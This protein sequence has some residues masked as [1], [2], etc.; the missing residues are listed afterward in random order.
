MNR[1]VD[2]TEEDIKQWE[3]ERQAFIRNEANESILREPP[4]EIWYAGNWLLRQLEALNCTK[5]LADEIA[6]A[7]GQRQAYAKDYWQ[8]VIE[9]VENYKKGQWES[10]G[11]GLAEKLIKE[12]F[13][14]NPDPME[15][16]EQLVRDGANREEL[17][18]LMMK[19][20]LKTKIC[21]KKPE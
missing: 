5:E 14:D 2:V 12:R 8:T 15:I 4:A 10:P 11:A 6:F 16:L 17:L 20:R 18:A 7:A 13:G 21:I 1:P 3:V 9:V 19:A